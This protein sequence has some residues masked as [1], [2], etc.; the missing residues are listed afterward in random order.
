MIMTRIDDAEALRLVR[1]QVQVGGSNSMVERQILGVHPIRFR[2]SRPPRRG[3]FRVG[4]KED[5]QVRTSAAGGQPVQIADPIGPEL[6]ADSLIGDG[7]IR[8]PV[9]ENMATIG[10]RWLDDLVKVVAPAGEE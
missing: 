7:G 9:A 10:Q 4:V 2:A 8:E 5:R 3:H 6:P 1:R